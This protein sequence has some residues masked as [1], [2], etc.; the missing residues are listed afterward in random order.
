MGDRLNL[1][2]QN[3]L[4]GVIQGLRNHQTV[5][6][7]YTTVFRTITDVIWKRRIPTIKNSRDF[8]GDRMFSQGIL[9]IDIS[10]IAFCTVPWLEFLQNSIFIPDFVHVWNFDLAPL[11]LFRAFEISPIYSLPG[12]PLKVANGIS[13]QNLE[14]GDGCHR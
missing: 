14:R 5:Q 8:L 2:F 12:A 1:D 4:V 9:L 3:N 13:E 11:E 10:N 6:N 7:F